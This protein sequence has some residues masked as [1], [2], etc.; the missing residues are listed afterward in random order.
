[1]VYDRY[2]PNFKDDKLLE[3]AYDTVTCNY[4]FNAIYD[5]QEHKELL[6]KIKLL[7]NNIYIRVIG[8]T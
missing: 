5:L 6:N 7:G 3:S 2:N 8:N 1:M 4:V